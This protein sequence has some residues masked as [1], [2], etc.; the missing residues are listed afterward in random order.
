[1]TT[2]AAENLDLSELAQ[3]APQ[4][5]RTCVSIASDIALVV[6]ADGIVRSACFAGNP[7]DL[8]GGDLVG[9]AWVDT[10]STDS[11][12][13]VELLLDEVRRTGVSRRRE[14]NHASAGGTDIPFNY[15][16]ISLGEGGPVIAAGR[17]LRSVAAI[18]KRFLDT[19]EEMEKDYWRHRRIES[20]YRCLFEVANDAV[21]IVDGLSLRIVDA[22]Q[23]A[24]DLF[25]WSREAAVGLDAGAG[26]EPTS[27]PAIEELLNVARS[28]GKPLELRAR[29]APD[30]LSIEISA[31]PFRSGQTLLLLVR[32]RRLDS[33]S[34]P[35]PPQSQE[36]TAATPAHPAVA[37]TDSAGR[38][39]IANRPFLD[40]SGR[41]DE[42]QVLGRPLAQVLEA[43]GQEIGA[44]L[45]EARRSGLAVG[46]TMRRDARGVGTPL[47]LSAT[48]M[49][50]GDQ[51]C[52]GVMLHEGPPARDLT[53]G[54]A[55]DIAALI[56]NF[57]AQPQPPSLPAILNSVVQKVEQHLIAQ[58][59][60]RAGGDCD[61]AALA[62][63]TTRADLE[64]RLRRLGDASG[65]P[66]N[67]D[68]R[69]VFWN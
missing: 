67:A 22:N 41:Q 20:R 12:R 10:V 69:T 64:A 21:L 60:K 33:R 31:T 44:I 63:G 54:F 46:A 29:S 8:A 34:R 43:S 55:P 40:L 38:I 17:D 1:M 35:T 51:E 13:K 19:Q 9:R 30:H 47:Q 68:A 5:A 37:I 18:Q 59:L 28:T 6:D 42:G 53:D 52:I 39:R 56:D 48:L 3:L 14:L 26:I 24:L 50:D 11:R 15:A 27:R 57:M 32:A 58:S 65:V 36:G 25:R 7:L 66:G 62:L 2:A 16:A 61:A 49:A 23:A 45:S 4:L